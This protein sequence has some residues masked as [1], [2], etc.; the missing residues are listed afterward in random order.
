MASNPPSL[1]CSQGFRHTGTPQGNLTEFDGT[2]VYVTGDPSSK[3]LLFFLTDV[4]GIRYPNCQ[5]LADQFAGAGYIVVAPDLYWKDPVKQDGSTD[6]KSWL[7]E[8]TLEKVEPIVHK[9][10]EWAKDKYKP[11]FIAS[12]GYCYGA[13]Y[14]LRL[15]NQSK[16]DV[17]ALNHPSF[18]QVEEVE[19]AK[20]PV[21]INAAAIDDI[22]TPEQRKQTEDI[23]FK[24]KARYFTTLRGGASHGFAIRG[25]PD[26][27]VEREAKEKCFSDDLWWFSFIKTLKDKKQL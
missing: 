8:H 16:I 14:S 22:Y 17:A 4:L 21:I 26:D 9:L 2:D 6:L 11:E 19:Q 10:L 27:L 7:A 15:L 25:N 24:N 5:L 18:I 1:C 3:K 13:R 12:T 20:G 23:L